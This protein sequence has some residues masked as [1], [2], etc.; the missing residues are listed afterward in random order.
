MPRI[1]SQPSW[2][3]YE[4]D[5]DEEWNMFTATLHEKGIRSAFKL[6]SAAQPGSSNAQEVFSGHVAALLRRWLSG[7][8]IEETEPEAFK[9]LVATARGRPH[10]LVFF[11]RPM[12]GDCQRVPQVQLVQRVLREVF[13][14]HASPP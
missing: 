14:V 4:E 6:A 3:A 10:K 9:V 2:E 11:A 5:L 1:P 12:P 8:A 7:S 13:D